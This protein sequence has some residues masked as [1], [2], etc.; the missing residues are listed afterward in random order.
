MKMKNKITIFLLIFTIMMLSISSF[1]K[2]KVE[3]KNQETILNESDFVDENDNEN[4]IETEKQTEED[5]KSD[6][7]EIKNN[8]DNY[9]ENVNKT[10]N[11][12]KNITKNEKEEITV[13]RKTPK[14]LAIDFLIFVKNTILENAIWLILLVILYFLYKKVK[15]QNPKIDKSEDN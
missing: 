7:E 4:Y 3:N 15:M 9:I 10:G 13:E 8:I 5:K 2:Q 11:N 14:E 6:F 12:I 1:A